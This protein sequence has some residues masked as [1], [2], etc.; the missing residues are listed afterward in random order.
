[1][2]RTWKNAVSA[3]CAA[4]MLTGSFGMLPASAE[5]E[6]IPRIMG[7][8][9][10]DRRITMQDA[11]KI[12]DLSV[13]GSIGLTDRKTN[14]E[15]NA[16]DINMNG[17][18]E[19]MDAL[20]VMRYFCQSLVGTQPLWSDIRKITYHDGTEYNL[21]YADHESDDE[22]TL[23]QPFERRGMYL[24]IGCA[25]G[26][27]GET[28]TVPVYIAGITKLSAFE[29]VQLIPEGLTLT[30]IQ[31]DLGT[32]HVRMPDEETGGFCWETV[33]EADYSE[34][35]V[36]AAVNE[37]EG[38]GTIAWMSVNGIELD[39]QKGM[40]IAN[41]TYQIPE[42][43]KSGDTYILSADTGKMRFNQEFI[44]GEYNYQ[45]TMLDGVIA[46]Q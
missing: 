27:A 32:E 36:S 10:G 19:M 37:A 44:R 45:Y 26:K 14:A 30:R 33:S 38:I 40:V 8:M 24:E 21:L 9:N 41:Y 20:A 7:D 17:A 42:D 13:M 34:A 18:I 29:Y 35:I 15:T 25:E 22:I 12:L 43:A 16:G 39:V 5:E 46:V 11:K 2:N 4:A 3:V 1:M 28:V 6:H 23:H 31:S